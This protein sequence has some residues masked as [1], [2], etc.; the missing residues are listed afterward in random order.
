MKPLELRLCVDRVLLFP[1]YIRAKCFGKSLCSN[2]EVEEVDAGSAEF[3]HRAG[4]GGFRFKCTFI[5]H[6]SLYLCGINS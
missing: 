4:G 3:M 5:V 6:L 2:E 1:L